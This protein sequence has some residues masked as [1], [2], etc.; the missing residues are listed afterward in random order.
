MNSEAL[1]YY[2]HEG[3]MALRFE[4]AG[5]VTADGAQRL[6]RDWRAAAAAI[7]NKALIVD[8]SFVTGID[9]AGRELLR[10]WRANGARLVGSSAQAHA[11]IESI[12]GGHVEE[13]A[14]VA[15]PRDYTWS[16]LHTT[17]LLWI[18]LAILLLPAPARAGGFPD[19][20]PSL[21]FARYL[22]ILQQTNPGAKPEAAAIEIE[23]S[24]PAQAKHARLVAIRRIDGLEVLRLEGDSTVKQQVIS[25]YLTAK[26]QAETL[27]PSSVAITPANYK[28]RYAGSIASGGGVVYVFQVAPRKKREGLIAGQ[29]WIDAEGFPV[30]QAGLL[31]KRP[32]VLVRRVE[33]TRD[34]NLRE[35]VS[36]THLV[37][38]TRLAG[39]AELTIRERPW[40]QSLETTAEASQGGGW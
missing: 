21:A 39:R 7:G 17:A 24:L 29:F 6:E 18:A 10:E 19:A 25:R 11:L 5:A 40:T 33:I 12:A 30:H 23:A 27:P 28:F 35:G 31:V 36:V 34:T 3:P 26:A 22:A 38:D 1:R 37:V 16:P 8:L 14:E 9:N 15:G 4:L 20:A 2:A 13:I 32:S